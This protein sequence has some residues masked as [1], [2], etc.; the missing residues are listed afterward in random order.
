M[1]A[2]LEHPAYVRADLNLD[3]IGSNE[4]RGTRLLLERMKCF[5][6]ATGRSNFTAKTPSTLGRA[7]RTGRAAAPGTAPPPG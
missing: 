5:L 7:L 6:P 4:I 2:I 3:W 1:K